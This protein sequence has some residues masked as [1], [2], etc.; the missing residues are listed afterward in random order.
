MAA[1]VIVVGAFIRL[2]AVFA[3]LLLDGR[4]ALKRIRSRFFAARCGDSTRGDARIVFYCFLN[5]A[6]ESDL[7]RGER[8]SVG[9]STL[10]DIAYRTDPSLSRWH[11]VFERDGEDWTVRDLG[12]KNGTFVD[13]VRAIARQVLRSGDRIMAGYTVIV[14]DEPAEPTSGNHASLE[15]AEKQTPQHADVAAATSQERQESTLRAGSGVADFIR[16]GAAT[17]LVPCRPDH[18]VQPRMTDE[19]RATDSSPGPPIPGGML[20]SAVEK[21]RLRLAATATSARSHRD[22]SGSATPTAA[23]HQD[24]LAAEQTG[25]SPTRGSRSDTA[26]QRVYP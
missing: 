12:S 8:I 9:R 14:Y 10:N 24:A 25:V 19:L 15:G 22:A 5:G 1:A 16:R 3:F 23:V 20:Q 2:L 7:L 21:S 6:T 11:L 26:R 4:L 18:P 13:G 17:T